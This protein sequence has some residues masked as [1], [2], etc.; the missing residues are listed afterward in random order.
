MW[1][2]HTS[3]QHENGSARTER[4][5]V[6]SAEKTLFRATSE[7]YIAQAYSS[8]RR[9]DKPTSFTSSDSCPDSAN[10]NVQK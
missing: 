9:E 10:N 4:V 8:P 7:G 6:A 5:A 1:Q 3:Q 2:C